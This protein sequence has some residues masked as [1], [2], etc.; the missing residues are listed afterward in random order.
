[1]QIDVSAYSIDINDIKVVLTEITDA[2]GINHVNPLTKQML[3]HLN[4]SKEVRND[5]I[6]NILVRGARGNDFI[7][8]KYDD[9]LKR[10][11]YTDEDLKYIAEHIDDVSIDRISQMLYS[12]NTKVIKTIVKKIAN[13]NDL[14]NMFDEIEGFAPDEFSTK[15]SSYQNV[16]DTLVSMKHDISLADKFAVRY[17]SSLFNKYVVNRAMRPKIGNS[18]YKIKN[19]GWAFENTQIA[20][21]E[22]MLG[23]NLRELNIELNNKVYKLGELWE[24]AQGRR[25]PPKGLSRGFI[26]DFFNHVAV[27][28]IPQDNPAGMQI[29]R[30]KGFSDIDSNEIMIHS[31]SKEVTGGSDDDGD[32]YYLWFAGRRDDGSGKGM[33]LSWLKEMKKNNDMWRG[34]KIKQYQDESG[35]KADEEVFGAITPPREY[36]KQ[37][38]STP[39]LLGAPGT[40]AKTSL[41][42]TYARNLLGIVVNNTTAMKQAY[43]NALDTKTPIIVSTEEGKFELIPKPE[44][45]PEVDW[46]IRKIAVAITKVADPTDF[47]EVPSFDE[48]AVEFYLIYSSKMNGKVVTMKICKK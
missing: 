24:I 40:T 25:K 20:R 22:F 38:M 44:T 47:D 21:D 5:I 48:P 2:A 13:I 10:N 42:T 41:A 34:Q 6:Q 18:V 39:V 29:L 19:R 15:Q 30:F 27:Q 46:A 7:N 36:L 17:I 23:R 28:R 8:L 4:Q 16:I 9:I 1:M 43:Y 31:T 14:N 33:K 11:E 26:Q 32:S 3:V 45:D 35:R 37:I 12:G